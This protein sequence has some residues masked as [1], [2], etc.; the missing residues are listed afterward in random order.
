MCHD[1]CM[2]SNTARLSS[3]SRSPL[4]V[5]TATI[6]G[7]MDLVLALKEDLLEEVVLLMEMMTILPEGGGSMTRSRSFTAQ[8]WAPAGSEKCLKF[9]QAAVWVQGEPYYR[10]LKLNTTYFSLQENQ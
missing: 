2:L 3:P 6:E 5:A 1:L 9:L 4:D 7:N 10:L 8:E